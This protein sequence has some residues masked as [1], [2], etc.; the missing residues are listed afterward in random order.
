MNSKYVWFAPMLETILAHK[1]AEPRRSTV[2]MKRLTS[3]IAS[4]APSDAAS[5]ADGAEEESGFSSVVRLG[6]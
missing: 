1:A 6:A 3:R 2:L 5:S 4:V